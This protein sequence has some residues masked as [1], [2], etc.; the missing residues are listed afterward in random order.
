[1]VYGES[2][3]SESLSQSFNQVC[4][5]TESGY[6]Y[7]CG[8]FTALVTALQTAGLVDALKGTG[9]FTVSL[10]QM[11]CLQKSRKISLTL[12]GKQDRID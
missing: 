8:N 10:L 11:R 1:M 12:D 9:P 4:P 3:P 2:T 6:S 7:G 5:L